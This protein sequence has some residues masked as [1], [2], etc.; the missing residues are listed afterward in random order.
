MEYYEYWKAGSPPRR[1]VPSLQNA[2]AWVNGQHPGYETYATD[3]AGHWYD[4][5]CSADA[6]TDVLIAYY[7]AHP[8][9]YVVPGATPPATDT[10]VPPQVLAQVAFEAMDLPTGTIDWNPK[11]INDGAAVVGR[12][13][14]VWIEG[15]TR[16]VT[17]TASVP[18]LSAQVTATLDHIDLTAPGA[19]KTKCPDTGTPWTAGAKK[20]TCTI[21]FFHSSANQP[22]KHG[23]K[24]PTATL[25]ATATWTA[26]WTSSL[27]PTVRALPTQ[28]LTTTAEVPVAEIE[29]IVVRGN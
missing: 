22:V 21:D 12:D 4:A 29:A 26:T 19:D 27:D 7:A 24:L 14:W 1:L 10:G 5:R 2:S 23:Q 11:L 3:T 20:S 28:K 18:G 25:T 6:P 17:V 15:A 8:P 13:T 9:V 16:T